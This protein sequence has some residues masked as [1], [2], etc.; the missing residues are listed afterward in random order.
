MPSPPPQLDPAHDLLKSD[1]PPLQA[2]FQPRTV[3]VIGASEKVGSV[4]RALQWNLMTNPFG[5]TVFPVNPKRAS[6]MGIKAYPSIGD[7]PEAVD[8]ALIATPAASVPNMVRQCVEA[9]VRAGIII[10]A[11]FRETGERGAALE[12][13]ILA[14]ARGRM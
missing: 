12:H 9:G 11:G 4:G 3:A 1:A 6:V 7:V 10:S 13:E 5:G 2:I 8:L 14:I